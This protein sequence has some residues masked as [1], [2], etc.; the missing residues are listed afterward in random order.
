MIIDQ[1]SV[2]LTDASTLQVIGTGFIYT[3]KIMNDR[4]YVITA[5]HCLY[6]DKDTFGI[7][8]NQIIVDFYHSEQKCYHSVVHEIDYNLVSPS[9]DIDIA[10][11][12]FKKSNIEKLVGTISAVHIIDHKVD[13]CH[14]TIKGFPFATQGKEL[15]SLSP[16]WI[17]EMNDSRRFQLSNTDHYSD[18]FM[19]GFSGSAV[20]THINEEL[21]LLGIVTRYRPEAQG[22]VIYCQF[23]S[24]I[25]SILETNFLPVIKSQIIG[26]N[27]L[28][29]GYF[30]RQIQSSILN[31]GPRFNAKLNY[32]LPIDD[33]FSDLVKDEHFKHRFT[34]T[35]DKWLTAHT[36]FVKTKKKRLTYIVTEHRKIK[37]EIIEWFNK[38]EWIPPYQI[39]FE[40]LNTKLND[41]AKSLD[42]QRD[43]LYKERYKIEK[44][45]PPKRE[46][47][48]YRPPFDTELYELRRIQED[49]SSFFNDLSRIN[50]NISNSPCLI[51]H[52]EAGCGKSH[53]LGDIA[54]ER[55]LQLQPTI[56]LLG[57]SFQLSKTVW[58]NILDQLEVSCTGPELLKSLDD[59]GR[60]NNNRSLILIDALN[61]GDGINLWNDQLPGLIGEVLQYP[62][63]AIVMSV[64]TTFLNRIVPKQIQNDSR[65][66]LLK[67]TGFKGNEYEALR[68]FCKFYNLQLPNFPLLN[69][70]FSNPL[71]LRL[72]CEGVIASNG[73]SFPQ[74]FQG[75]NAA[76][77]FYLKSVQ[78]KIEKKREEYETSP[79][80]VVRATDLI[81]QALFKQSPHKILM[82]ETAEQM[83]R[84]H[85][86][87]HRYLLKDLIQEDVFTRGLSDETDIVH[88]SY[89]RFGDAMI[90][91]KLLSHYKTKDDLLPAFEKDGVLGKLVTEDIWSNAG[92]LEAIAVL[93]PELFDLEIIEVYDWLFDNYRDFS[94]R[95]LAESIELYFF[96]SLKWRTIS[97]INT[98]KVKAWL[99]SKQRMLSDNDVLLFLYE[100]TT[101]HNH[102]FNSDRLFR[103]LAPQTLAKR[104][105]FFQ[106]HLRY[107]SQKDDSG[108]AYPIRRLIDWSWQT[109]ISKRIDSET[110]R[111]AAQSLCWVLSTT[112]R[113]LRDEASKALVNLLEQQSKVLIEILKKFKNVNDPYILERLYGIAYGCVLRSTDVKS[114][115][116]ISQFIYNAIFKE[117]NP[118]PHI[119]LRDYARCAIEYA[120]TLKIDIKIDSSKIRPPYESFFPTEIPT[121]EEI[122][123]LDLDHST[124]DYKQNFGSSHYQILHSVLHWD[125]ARYT[126]NSAV[127]IF[128]PVSF[129][130]PKAHAM[131][132]KTLKPST[133]RTLRQFK[134]LYKFSIL[135]DAQLARMR[136][137]LGELTVDKLV[138]KLTQ[139]CIKIEQEL[140]LKLSPIEIKFLNQRLKIYWTELVR[141]TETLNNEFRIEPIQRWI[142]QRV[143]QLGY[144]RKKHGPYDSLVQSYSRSE[145]RIERI[146]KKYQW[147]AFYEILGHLADNY[148][149]KVDRWSAKSKTKYYNGPW[150]LYVRNIDPAFTTRSNNQYLEEEDEYV[151]NS[152]AENWWQEP[153]YDGWRIPT[154]DWLQNLNDI[155]DPK[156]LIVIKDNAGTQWLQLKGHAKWNEPRPIGEKKYTYA[157]R[158]LWYYINA[159]IVKTKNKKRVVQW[160]DENEIWGHDLPTS[161]APVNL[162]SRENY[163]APIVKDHPDYY[164][165]WR[166][167][168]GTKLKYMIPTCD[169]IGELSE[170]KSGAHYKY[171][172]PAKYIFDAMDLRFGKIDGDF[173]N[174]QGELLVTNVKSGNIL[175]KSEEFKKFLKNNDLDIIW[176]AWGEKQSLS[177]RNN[178]FNKILGIF[179]FDSEGIS[180][181]FKSIK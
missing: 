156:E 178:S 46:D 3:S 134:E 119:L 111:L 73:A 74:G 95:N 115:K 30:N 48:S 35:V 85:F 56:L 19:L 11:L 16:T 72:I 87:Q 181:Q 172:M 140:L 131:F 116:A 173:T 33:L 148:K 59:L 124:A 90:A 75:I 97:S 58:Q 105:S 89:E 83:F 49:L 2:R 34:K 163:W 43:A 40:H 22:K 47:H 158:E 169:A 101:V 41:F 164:K 1:I 161:S 103:I 162:Y 26:N 137:N 117:G 126:I 174:P 112:N 67:H 8:R 13:P 99:Q 108:N 94:L 121:E 14:F 153:P 21:Y 127:R 128:S 17:Q 78:I 106:S 4:L 37:H 98:S 110:C 24:S 179:Q 145:N 107:Y 76:F 60:R 80:L 81:A 82:L 70:E 54:S 12:I 114:V 176:I 84:D 45:N 170:D 18:H 118:P 132:I 133:A 123:K 141:S 154:I 57:Q 50:L 29:P 136:N 20:F 28:T 68:L 71:F 130:E 167:I 65:V 171:E 149:I 109:G 88:F 25:N 165:P 151:T 64:R 122:K 129:T 52:G 139:D 104:D 135:S 55:L 168:N 91:E 53:L 92:V 69:P 144:D 180:G 177:D 102:P 5:A 38:I 150:E 42:D 166:S 23:I 86:P 147:I 113:A 142:V 7:P 146:G 63:I 159:Y 160:F 27:G 10:I 138:K 31:L 125:F 61:E 66:T 157:R 79:H 62:N 32:K 39:S 96:T 155:P 15:A 77:N 152:K 6:E 143:F 100:V 120:I 93:L 44:K 51:L 175:I 36:F 9:I